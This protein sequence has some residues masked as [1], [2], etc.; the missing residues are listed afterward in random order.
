MASIFIAMITTFIIG[1]YKKESPLR[2]HLIKNGLGEP[3]TK[4]YCEFLY[5]PSGRLV[6]IAYS[7][8]HASS[9]ERGDVYASY[10]SGN[11]LGQR[12]GRVRKGDVRK[13]LGM[14]SHGI[15]PEHTHEALRKV[16]VE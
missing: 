7:G 10:S 12:H 6:R 11:G 4:K 2:R 16:E 3:R 9:S 5:F 15:P 14:L 8:G 1:I 13:R